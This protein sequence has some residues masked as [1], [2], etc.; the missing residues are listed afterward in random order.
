MNMKG[1]HL[2]IGLWGLLLLLAACEK[3]GMGD[4]KTVEVVFSARSAGYGTNDEILRSIK[5]IKPERVIVPL[6]DDFYFSATLMPDTASDLRAAVFLE[7]NQKIKL[8][9]FDGGTE[10]TGSPVTYTY[11]TGTGR[12]TPVGAP[13]GVEPGATVYRFAAY[14]YYGDPTATPD[15]TGIT[16]DKDLAQLLILLHLSAASKSCRLSRAALP[17]HSPNHIQLS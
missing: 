8:A 15:E 1:R 17:V 3:D 9:A 14:S 5:A 12:F 16:G 13:L 6:D 2:L 10:V 4:G 11:S 7:N